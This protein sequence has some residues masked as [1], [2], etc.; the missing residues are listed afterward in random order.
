MVVDNFQKYQNSSAIPFFDLQ[1]VLSVPFFISISGLIIPT[2]YQR[3]PSPPIHI[4]DTHISSQSLLFCATLPLLPVIFSFL[5]SLP[6]FDRLLVFAFGPLLL[7]LDLSVSSFS[8]PFIFLFSTSTLL[9]FWSPHRRIKIAYRPLESSHHTV[10]IPSWT[11][12]T[13]QP[14]HNTHPNNTHLFNAP[15]R[16]FLRYCAHRA[17]QTLIRSPIYLHRNPHAPCLYCS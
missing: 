4:I 13:N 12:S 6:S 11:T 1:L 16:P 3:H 10:A 7:H 2:H 5:F 14:T 8:F 17:D 15:T 9:W